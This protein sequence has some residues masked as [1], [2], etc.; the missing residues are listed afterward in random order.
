MCKAAFTGFAVSH[1]RSRW[2][3]RLVRF[4]GG[5]KLLSIMALSG[6]FPRGAHDAPEGTDRASAQGTGREPDRLGNI[7]A[8][9]ILRDEGVS[10]PMTPRT[11]EWV[12]VQVNRLH[13]GSVGPTVTRQANPCGR[14]S[15]QE[16]PTSWD[17]T[18]GLPCG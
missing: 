18:Q 6:E 7:R 4:P 2:G 11:W 17:L 9:V 1:S 8:G 13:H 3:A 15:S 12:Y 10:H 14:A 16:C 5:R